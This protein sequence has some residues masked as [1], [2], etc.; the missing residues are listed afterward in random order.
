MGKAT[1]TSARAAQLTVGSVFQT[2]WQSIVAGTI[3]LAEAHANLALRI[4]GDV[5][6]PLKDQRRDLQSMNSLQANLA[7]LAKDVDR[8]KKRSTSAQNNAAS[9]WESQAPYIFEQLQS[10]D[11]NRINQMREALTQLQ[12]HEI[13]CHERSKNSAEGSLNALLNVDTPEEVSAFVART[14]SEIP[15]ESAAEPSRID[16]SSRRGT[17]SRSDDAPMSGLAPPRAGQRSTTDDGRSEISEQ[18]TETPKT[19]KKSRFGGLRRLGT[20]M[21]RR[22]DKDKDIDSAKSPAEKRSMRRNPLRRNSSAMMEAIPSPNESTTELPT[23]ANT[24]RTSTHEETPATAQS[25]ARTLEP[26]AISTSNQ[27][28][29]GYSAY[30]SAT[31]S[32]RESTMPSNALSGTNGSLASSIPQIGIRP[33]STIVE[34][35][36]GSSILADIERAQQEANS[37]GGDTAFNLNIRD[38]PIQEE[39]S[40]AAAAAAANVS[41]TLR[42]SQMPPPQRRSGTLRGRRDVRNTM[43]VPN[44]APEMIA[45]S[46][47]LPAATSPAIGNIGSLAGIS[48]HRGA[49][50]QSIRSSHSMA[51]ST[52]PGMIKHADM[53]TPGLNASIVETSSATF[54]DGAVSKATVI[55][56]LALVH[57]G[58]VTSTAPIS[59]RLDNFQVLEKVAPNPVFVNQVADRAGEYSLDESQISRPSVAF[60]YQIHLTDTALATY[61]PII[62]NPQSRF[63]PNQTLVML[64]Y[65]LNPAFAPPLG[66]TAPITISNLVIVLNLEGA[67]ATSCQSKPPGIFSREKSLIYWKLGDVTFD[68]S[69]QGEQK[70]LAKFATESTAMSASAEARWELKGA[71]SGLGV[72]VLGEAASGTSSANPFADAGTSSTS[73]VAAREVQVQRR[74]TAGRY[75]AN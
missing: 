52:G 32:P 53:T 61:S 50:T 59:I 72:S 36:A 40:D 4:E 23:F 46:D 10:L 68:A 15:S 3:A 74:L 48:E 17:G 5:E 55:G 60:K 57:N 8:N 54:T 42:A 20:V 31:E 30:G 49:D 1:N 38:R 63:E 26:N 33:P 34:E 2:P 14:S 58:P 73:L 75:L 62:I 12:T 66:A 47:S 19:E 6:S 51:S 69:T 41:N 21:S 37:T 13:D 35:G 39:N 65:H 64:N 28:N 22:K 7:A 71:G 70:L 16:P 24:R 29:G 45:A 56:E 43:F 27:T 9:S 25:I 44:P 11:E 67:R 18:S